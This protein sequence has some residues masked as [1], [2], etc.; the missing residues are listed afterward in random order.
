MNYRR[1]L[2]MGSSKVF[3]GV[4][5]Y[6]V[7]VCVWH[8]TKCGSEKPAS[9]TFS[10]SFLL[11]LAVL[12]LSIVQAAGSPPEHW[13]HPRGM[14][15][16]DAL[17]HAQAKAHASTRMHANMDAQERTHTHIHTAV[18]GGR[19]SGSNRWF[20]NTYW[21]H[22]HQGPTA[23]K[24]VSLMLWKLDHGITSQKSNHKKTWFILSGLTFG[25]RLALR[26]TP[27]RSLSVSSSRNLRVGREI[28][29]PGGKPS[30]TH[31]EGAK[32]TEKEWVYSAC[33]L[34]HAGIGSSSPGDPGQDKCMGIE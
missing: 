17:T 20:Q 11:S 30:P 22:S 6:C 16:L 9:L 33:L 14:H 34:M 26:F 23:D 21:N 3:A 7:C 32:S 8:N 10:F 4:L 5:H 15:E 18:S 19:I 12:T 31:G 24:L 2:P 25:A 1:K 29:A 13:L 28:G 27:P